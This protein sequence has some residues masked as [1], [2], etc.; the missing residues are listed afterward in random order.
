MDIIKETEQKQLRKNLSSF[1]VGDKVK[2]EEQVVEQDKTRIQVF[3]G[4][5]IARKG[6]GIS[7]TFTVRK[8]SHGEGVEKIFPLQSPLIKEIKVIREG[9]V[10]R[11]K[12]YYLRRKIGKGAKVEEKE[13]EIKVQ[14][15]EPESGESVPVS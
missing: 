12:L 7:E 2:V 3:E 15:G 10:R 9:K 13:G 8:I 14:L 1:R 5:V 11:A 6:G 4:V